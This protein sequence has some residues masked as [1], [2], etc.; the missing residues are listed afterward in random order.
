MKTRRSFLR[1]LAGVPLLGIV[2]DL[3]KPTRGQSC[4]VDI[5]EHVH[6]SG[7]N[8]VLVNDPIT[9]IVYRVDSFA[10]AGG[11][12]RVHA[13]EVGGSLKLSD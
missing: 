8:S 7:W 12:T 2:F 9:G 11:V 13:T 10:M 1:S 4:I 5:P 6:M 3:P